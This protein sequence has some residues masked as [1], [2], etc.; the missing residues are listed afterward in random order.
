M[1]PGPERP[2]VFAAPHVD[3]LAVPRTDAAAIAAAL[4]SDRA[5]LVPVWR[6]RSL[7][8]REPAPAALLLPVSPDLCG[9]LSPA[10]PILLGEFAGTVAF[11]AELACAEP[12]ALA[13]GAEFVDLRLTAGLLDPREAGLLAYARAMVTW[14][15]QHRHCGACGTPLVAERAGHQM[16]CPRQGCGAQWFPRLDP[17]IIVLV[18]HGDRALLGRQ[19]AW[20]AGR[21]STLAGFVE[22]GESLEDTVRREVL[23]E[24]G[25]RVGAMTYHSSQPWPFPSSIM[26]GFHATADTTDI[27]LG[28]DELEDARWFSREEIAAGAAGLPPPQSVSYRLIEHWYDRGAARPLAEERGVLSWTGRR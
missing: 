23:E 10:E 9:L 18:E 5:R 1:A 12:P 14:R 22:P 16:R 13:P 3:R 19:A 28:D 21:Y 7:I 6:N 26:I 15:A 25:V 24:T 4:A 2:N 8:V 11:A 20:P 17:A 27:A